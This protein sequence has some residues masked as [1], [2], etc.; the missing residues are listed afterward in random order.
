MLQSDLL[1]QST[2]MTPTTT[3]YDHW[4]ERL[5]TFTS[6]AKHCV[7]TSH[8]VKRKDRVGQSWQMERMRRSDVEKVDRTKESA[9]ARKTI[10]R[11]HNS[12]KVANQHPHTYTKS[13]DNAYQNYVKT[14]TNTRHLPNGHPQ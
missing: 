10:H 1:T 6:S 11:A 14:T 12:Q 7:K 3:S 4:N 2:G 9:K 5:L 8:C 13:S